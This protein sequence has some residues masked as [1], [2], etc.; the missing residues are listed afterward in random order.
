MTDVAAQ[1][2][3]LL[4]LSKVELE[5]FV[6]EMGAGEREAGASAHAVVNRRGGRAIGRTV[7]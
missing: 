5:A 1:R 4:G 7:S 2:T 6:G 3:N